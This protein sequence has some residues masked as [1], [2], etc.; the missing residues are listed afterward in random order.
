MNA[1]PELRESDRVMVLAPHPDDETLGAG[2]ALQQAIAAG[3]AVRVVFAT[4]GEANPWPQRWIERRWHLNADDRQRWGARRSEEARDA[5]SRLGVDPAAAVFMGWPDGG[6]LP[7]LISDGDRVI[8]QLGSLLA[9]FQPTRVILP[10]I[11]DQHPDHSA[12]NLI[13]RAALLGMDEQRNPLLLEFL[14]HA[15]RKAR[16][17]LDW[18]QAAADTAL[19]SFKLA[20]LEAHNTQLRLNRRWLLGR[21]RAPEAFALAT[22]VPRENTNDRVRESAITSS[23]SEDGRTRLQFDADHPA[24]GR[25]QLALSLAGVSPGHVDIWRCAILRNPANPDS[26]DITLTDCASGALLG[27]ADY[28]RD[29]SRVILTLPCKLPGQLLYARFA[30]PRPRLKV[31]DRDVWQTL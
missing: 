28:L 11:R 9:A 12:L 2:I 10:C 13:A 4:A 30:R 15:H 27:H 16:A 6:I 8:A 22:P 20:A 29:G 14:L 19:P 18:H 17:A 3:A 1:I 21:A 23:T 31:I 25:F 7:L 5:L 26:A 24:A